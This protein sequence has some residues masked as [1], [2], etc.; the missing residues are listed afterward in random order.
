MWVTYHDISKTFLHNASRSIDKFHVLMEFSRQFNTVR[1]VCMKKYALIKNAYYKEKLI[2]KLKP[3]E[4]VIYQEAIMNYYALKKFNWLFYK[5]NSDVLDPNRKKKFNRVFN[6]Y[7]NFYDIFSY[8][9]SCDEILEEACNLKYDLDNFYSKCNRDNAKE[10]LE[11]LIIEFRESSIDEMR[12]FSGTLAGWKNEI[13]NSFIIIDNSSINNGRIE[14]INRIIKTL[15]RNANRYTNFE[16]LRRRI[17]WCVN[18][19]GIIT[20]PRKE[21]YTKK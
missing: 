10:N 3:D 6:R 14:C 20:M 1:C 21:D 18:K 4:E 17:M 15:K 2:R 12:H 11:K 9:C 8:M 13:I 16:R 19:D 5:Y 7:M